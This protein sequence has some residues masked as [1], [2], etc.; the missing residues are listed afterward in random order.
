VWSVNEGGGANG[1]TAFGFFG[2]TKQ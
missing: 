2:A 1:K